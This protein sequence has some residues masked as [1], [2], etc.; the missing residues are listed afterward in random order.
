M[1]V[2]TRKYFSGDPLTPDELSQ[3]I[4]REK[5]GKVIIHN[6]APAG[7]LIVQNF[8]TS[9]QCAQ[10][11]Q[12]C[13]AWKGESGK[14]LSSGDEGDIVSHEVD[15]R[16]VESISTEGFRINIEDLMRK[17]FTDFVSPHFEQPLAWCE[18]PVILRYPEGGEYYPHADAYNWNPDEKAWRRVTNRDYSLL[19]Y[20]NE[21]YEGGQLEFK[22][23]NY[24]IA[25]LQGLLVAFPSDWRYAH[26]ALPVKRGKKHS[27]VSFAAAKETPRLDKPLP[28]NLIKL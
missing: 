9:D 13:K 8:L 27:I 6:A 22:Y 28:P 3:E 18:K 12:E 19:I 25:P 2:E 11:M 14:V 16:K 26:A 15:S 21:D 7:L 4:I 24:R 5:P 20:L 17:A 10:I 23:L 1:T